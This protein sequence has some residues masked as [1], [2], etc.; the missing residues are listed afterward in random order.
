[1]PR[2]PKEGE[3]RPA[4]VSRKPAGW[5]KADAEALIRDGDAEA[6]SEAPPARA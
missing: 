6:Y 3:K 4:D 2:G 1:M 5:R